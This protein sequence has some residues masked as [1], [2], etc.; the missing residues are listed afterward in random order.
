M[1]TIKARK[2]GGSKD[3][4]L[5]LP[6]GLKA[7]LKALTGRTRRSLNMEVVVALEAW[8]S[9]QEKATAKKGGKR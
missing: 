6:A 3:V 2:K 8:V 9:T 4:Y 5:R 7:R 1:A